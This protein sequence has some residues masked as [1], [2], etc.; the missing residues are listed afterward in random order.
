V[1]SDLVCMQFRVAGAVP[2][3]TVNIALLWHICTGG[4]KEN[5]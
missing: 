1:V 5:G 4:V 2:G 3:L